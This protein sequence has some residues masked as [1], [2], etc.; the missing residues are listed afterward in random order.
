MDVKK[1]FCL[2]SNINYTRGS[3]HTDVLLAP[4]Q[5]LSLHH[6]NKDEC[7]LGTE[8]TCSW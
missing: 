4:R 1:I 6:R 3:L 7:C 8:W 5:R 2:S